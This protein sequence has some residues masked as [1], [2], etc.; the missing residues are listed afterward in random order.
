MK[1]KFSVVHLITREIQLLQPPKIILVKYGWIIKKYKNIK[2]NEFY[3]NYQFNYL[4][5]LKENYEIY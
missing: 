4:N 2:N 5:F 1:M 3:L